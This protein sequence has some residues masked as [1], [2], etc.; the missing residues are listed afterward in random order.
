MIRT[1][2]IAADID[3][4]TIMTDPTGEYIISFADG[5]WV[6]ISETDT[7]D[8]GTRWW[9]ATDYDGAGNEIGEQ[10]PD[11]SALAAWVATRNR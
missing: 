9:S 7:E 1:A 11:L 4:T 3:P 6:A 2:L 8:D 5:Y 10:S